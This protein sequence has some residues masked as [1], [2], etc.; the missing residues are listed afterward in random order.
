MSGKR[1]AQYDLN[2]DNW[3]QDEEPE[4]KGAFKTASQDEL[5]NRVI[6]KARRKMNTSV[7]EG[8]TPKLGAFSSFTGK[9]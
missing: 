7:M 9:K 1:N 2:Q 6:K 4:E 8:E 3:D 5:N